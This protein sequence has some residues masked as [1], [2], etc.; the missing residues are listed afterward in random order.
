MGRVGADEL[1]QLVL[2]R[3]RAVPL[4]TGPAEVSGL[5]PAAQVHEL[6]RR[7]PALSRGEAR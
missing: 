2:G 7:L 6:T 1:G 5:I 3:L 4:S